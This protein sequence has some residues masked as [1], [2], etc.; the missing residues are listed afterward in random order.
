MMRKSI[1][2][3]LNINSQKIDI[4]ETLLYYTKRLNKIGEKSKLDVADININ[5][6]QI[7]DE[8]LTIIMTIINEYKSKDIFKSIKIRSHVDNL[9]YLLLKNL[10]QMNNSYL[11]IK[12]NKNKSDKK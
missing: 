12:S 5:L 1:K 2:N 6:S 9:I 4:Y 11:K 3:S 7:K 8:I 10:A